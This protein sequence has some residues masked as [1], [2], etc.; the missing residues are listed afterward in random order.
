M[1]ILPLEGY[2]IRYA[3]GAAGFGLRMLLQLPRIRRAVRR[4]RKWLA[5]TAEAERIDAVISDNRL[6]LYHPRLPCVIMTHQL[7]IKSPFGART[8]KWLQRVNYH[9]IEKFSACWVVD[10][11]GPEN[12]AGA[13]SH[14]TAP[15]RVPLHYLGA[16]SR[17]QKDGSAVC[18]GGLLVLISGPE[19]QRTVFERLVVRQATALDTP[20][21]IVTGRPSAPRDEMLTG[22]V[23]VVNHL[24]SAALGVAMQQSRRILCRSGYSSVMDLV[25]L[26]GKAILV[27]TPGQTE[28]QYLADS[29]MKK[30]HFLSVAQEHFDLK[31]ALRQ[32]ETFPFVPFPYRDPCLG[33]LKQ[34]VEGL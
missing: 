29:L 13:L 6:G 25:S 3:S 16:L 33:I 19:P 18:A 5:A 27:P 22:R 9:Y 23:R 12:L 28:Q 30:G 34:F 26:G 31:E 32:A 8:E 14:P 20:A 10:Y 24:P 2:G 15:P 4:E 7:L 17:F 1:K 21:L 11:A